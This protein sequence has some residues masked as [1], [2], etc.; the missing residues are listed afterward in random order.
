MTPDLQPVLHAP[1][2]STP[3]P[4]TLVIPGHLF[5]DAAGRVR[6]DLPRITVRQD[7]AA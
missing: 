6:R 4:R 7:I 5:L 3:Q 1:L 2:P